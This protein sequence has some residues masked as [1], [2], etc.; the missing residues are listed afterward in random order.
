MSGKPWQS[1]APH[2]LQCNLHIW[3]GGWAVGHWL[4]NTHTDNTHNKHGKTRTQIQ[5]LPKMS[6]L[7]RKFETRYKNL[8]CKLYSDDDDDD[9]GKG[10]INLDWAQIQ[11]LP[12]MLISWCLEKSGAVYCWSGTSSLWRICH[13][14][15]SFWMSVWDF[16]K[17]DKGTEGMQISPKGAVWTTFEADNCMGPFRRTFPD[18]SEWPTHGKSWSGS[19]GKH[20]SQVSWEIYLRFFEIW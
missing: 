4:H 13:Q 18:V 2:L 11:I 10:N 6:I 15:A 3:E 8:N 19:L 5:N 14:R 9:E 20:L 17:S 7:R 16:S 12:K 1:T